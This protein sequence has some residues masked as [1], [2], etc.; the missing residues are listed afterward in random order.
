VH[1]GSF[2]A[3]T[4]IPQLYYG[5]SAAPR[6]TTG[7]EK[8]AEAL[9]GFLLIASYALF[10]A[11]GLL[12]FLLRQ[13]YGL[14]L[15]TLLGYAAGIWIRRSLGLRG[16]KRTT[17]FFM[18]MR[19]RAQGARPGLLEGLLEMIS[20]RAFT[21]A[22]CKAVVQTYEKAVRGLKGARTPEEKNKILAEL[23]RR[24]QQIL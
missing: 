3:P 17:G 22:Q 23:D 5:A 14:V 18:R 2:H 9:Y 12:G 20:G 11:A 8:L 16:R 4:R 19:E 21:Q 24:V 6:S 7:R 1:K 10:A 13:A 15:G